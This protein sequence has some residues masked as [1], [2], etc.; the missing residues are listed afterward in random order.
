MPN[1]D[2]TCPPE[3]KEAKEIT[4]LIKEKVEID[5]LDDEEEPLRTTFF[6]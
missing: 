1:G 6:P 5:T 2:P 3:V 4:S